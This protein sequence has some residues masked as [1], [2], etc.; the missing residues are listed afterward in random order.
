M[1]RAVV[2]DLDGTLIHT[3]ELKAQ[4]YAKAAVEIK[5]NAFSEQTAIE[6]F[7]TFVGRSREEVSKGLTDALD[8]EEA[9]HLL[10]SRYDVSEPW[11]VLTRLRIQ[12]YDDMIADTST[13]R[14]S[15]WK[16]NMDLLSQV[17]ATNCK[18][19][20]ATMSHCQ[21]M[22][23]VLKALELEGVFDFIATREDV[24]Y[25]KPNPEIYDLAARALGVVPAEMMVI[26]DSVTGV[27]AGIAAGAAVLAVASAMTRE[28]L[29]QADL[30]DQRYIINGPEELQE[31]LTGLI[32]DR[33]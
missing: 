5:P 6:V 13:L 11:Q 32:K 17:R 1:I 16:Q 27:R 22:L 3:E 26:E 10:M 18:L 25:P 9:A 8:L 14:A 19:G 23:I 15:A 12:I 28:S 31:K 29:H 24:V 33:G 7:K 4:S 2:F 30:L 20:L 21:H